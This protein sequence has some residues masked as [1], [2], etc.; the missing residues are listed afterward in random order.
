MKENSLRFAQLSKY[1]TTLLAD[2][3]ARMNKFV[4][5]VYELV[6]NKCH[7]EMLIPTMNISSLMVH[8]KQIEKQ[9]LKKMNKKVKRDMTN[10]AN[11]YN[12]SSKAK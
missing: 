10:D 4:M 8:A 11:F 7:L 9:K 2:S 1:A 3:R 12:A 6:E 5:G